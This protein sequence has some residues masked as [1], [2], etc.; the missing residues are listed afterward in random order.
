MNELLLQQLKQYTVLCVE[1]EEIIRK[2]IVNTLK[3]YFKDVFEASNG[4]DGYDKYAEYKP[5]IILSDIQMP[6]K[7]GIKMV[8][9]IRK[10][11][12]T[13]LIIML[14]AYSS[15]EYLLQLINLHINHYIKKPIDSDTLLNGIIKAFGNKLDEKIELGVDIYFDMKQRELIFEEEIVLLRKRDKDFLLL[16]YENKNSITRYDQIEEYLWV[17]KSMSMSALKTFVKELRQ[18]LPIDLIVNIQQEGYKLSTFK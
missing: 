12:L 11:D 1:D 7:S 8:E 17:D 5:D 15:E 6:K 2:G 10:E 14:T 9:Q 13:T 18:R 16:L 3:Y 4:D